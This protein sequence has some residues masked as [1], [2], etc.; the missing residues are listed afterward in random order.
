MKKIVII[1]G[2][3]AGLSAGIFAQKNDFESTILEK[4]HTPGGQCTGWDRQGYHIDGCIHW[5]LG[6]KEGTPINKLWKNVGALDGVDIINPESF[7]A[8]E[9]EGTTVHFYR[10][11]ERL[12]SSWTEI[13][14]EDENTIEEFCRDIKT[15]QSFEIPVG[16]PADMLNIVEKARLMLSMK[17]AGMIMQKYG[18]RSLTEYAKTFKHPALRD[19]LGSF[20]PEGFSASSIFFALAG[21]TKVQAGI[22]AGGSRAMAM[23]MAERY[24]SLDGTIETSSEV[25]EVNIQGKEV[26][27]VTCKNGKNYEADFFIAACDAHMLYRE[28]LKGQYPD[29]DFEVRFNNPEDYPL[30][31]NIYIGIGYADTMKEVPR[32]LKFQVDSFKI[33]E[34]PIK[35]LQMTH[36]GYEPNFAPKGH[37]VI[38][39]AINQ[40]QRD[41]GFWEELSKDRQAYKKEKTRIGA[42]VVRAMET[43]FPYMQGKLKLLDVATPRTYERYCNAY[44]G[45]FMAFWPTMRGKDLNHTGKIQGLT[46]MVL[47]GQWLMPP[48]GLPPALITGKHSIMR[49]CRQLKRPYIE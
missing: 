19:A 49:L 8:V 18:K 31:S 32:T 26:R 43:R 9:H 35:Y 24:L 14:P 46:N 15:L 34:A 17:D 2:G 44:R 30:A 37:T 6:T 48:G 20:S 7:M 42:E 29:P 22:P 25:V 33:N 27:S 1:G 40:F 11:L 3:V 45:V 23:R 21:F 13:S 5:L 38:T 39:F 36:Y 10:D 41:L 16:K 28:L 4:H 47:S 12:R